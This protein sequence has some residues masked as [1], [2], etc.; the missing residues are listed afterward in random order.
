ML[1]FG[2]LDDLN[3]LVGLISIGDLNAYQANNQERT[4]HLLEQYIYGQ[5]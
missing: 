4:I 5:V 3:Q 1:A 2:L